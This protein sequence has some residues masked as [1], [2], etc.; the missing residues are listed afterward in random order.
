MTLAITL[1]ADAATGAGVDFNAGFAAFFA[2]FTPFGFP[3][4]LG[5]E[6]GDETTQ[7]LHLDTPVT[8]S[9]AATRAVIL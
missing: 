4:F 3:V 9:E 5:P 7:I 8:G 6:A 1:T 2:D